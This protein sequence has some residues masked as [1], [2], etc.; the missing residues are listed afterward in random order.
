TEVGAITMLESKKALNQDTKF[1]V[2]TVISK[3]PAKEVQEKV[4]AVLRSI[5]K[6][7]VALFLGNKPEY[8]E[9]AIY[10][11]YTLEEAAV[12]SVQLS[13]ADTAPS[14]PPTPHPPTPT[15]A[16]HHNAP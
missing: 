10:H 6:P 1:K 14:H 11:A 8:Q 15:P 13:N 2:I 4:E 16:A 7:V 3:P 9:D 5:D 12:A